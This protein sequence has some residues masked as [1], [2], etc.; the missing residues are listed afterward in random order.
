MKTFFLLCLSGPLF[1]VEARKEI[2]LSAG[3]INT[4]Q[5]LF[6]S[7]IG[8]N[9]TLQS[10]GIAPVIDLPAV[11]KNLSDHPIITLSWQV[12]SSTTYDNFNRNA[13]ILNAE[14]IKWQTTREGP[15]ANGIAQHIGFV[16][17][18]DNSSVFTNTI[19]PASGPNSPHFEIFV[20]VS[21]F[22]GI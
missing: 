16:R 22:A 11:G 9:A 13:T 5:I 12:N 20:S 6:N 18:P 7:G 19:N 21:Y 1:S 17:V 3:S 10:M 14:I 4:P 15:L 8:D 2:V